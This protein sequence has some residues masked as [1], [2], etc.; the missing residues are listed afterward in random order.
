M[1]RVREGETAKFEEKKRRATG[2]LSRELQL[3]SLS[4]GELNSITTVTALMMMSAAAAPLQQSL[5]N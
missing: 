5:T 4:V 1:K 3:L 2:T